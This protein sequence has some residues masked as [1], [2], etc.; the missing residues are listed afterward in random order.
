MKKLI[1]WLGILVGIPVAVLYMVQSFTVDVWVV[2][3]DHQIAP[4]VAP[5]MNPGDSVRIAKWTGA[6]L[7]HLVKCAHPRGDG[8]EVVGRVIAE[9]GDRVSIGNESPS[10]NGRNSPSLRNCGAYTM[11]SPANGRD[12]TLQCY[13]EEHGRGVN[14]LR[15]TDFFDHE[16]EHK[17]GPGKVFLMSDNRHIHYDSRDFGPVDSDTCRPIIMRVSSPPGTTGMSTGLSVLW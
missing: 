11:K 10:V 7:G 4:S 15:A 6:A 2:P 17:V 13:V 14:V 5:N 12:V 8:G 16:S 9:S 3:N 1:I